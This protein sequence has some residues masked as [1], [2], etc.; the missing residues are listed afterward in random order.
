MVNESASHLRQ[1]LRAAVLAG[2]ITL[3]GSVPTGLG[4]PINSLA[5]PMDTTCCGGSNVVQM[6]TRSPS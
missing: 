6:T 4:S 2:V 5:G 3:A 1:G